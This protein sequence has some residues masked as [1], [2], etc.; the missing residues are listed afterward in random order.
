[1]LDKLREANF[2]EAALW[3]EK[4][5]YLNNRFG[6]ENV[7]AYRDAEEKAK[8][9][10]EENDLRWEEKL[11]REVGLA[12]GRSPTKDKQAQMEPQKMDRT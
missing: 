6:E 7:K 4:F 10:I 8:R 2:Q 9:I 12:S 11:K 1:M 3:K 5:T